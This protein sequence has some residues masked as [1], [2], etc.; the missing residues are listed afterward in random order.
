MS[1]AE[2][3]SFLFPIIAKFSD[4]GSADT[5]V[6]RVNG[7]FQSIDVNGNGTIEKGEWLKAATSST[8]LREAAQEFVELGPLLQP[9]HWRQE[10]QNLDT[11]KDSHVSATEFF[12][13]VF[14][15]VWK[16]HGIKSVILSVFASV[17]K[18]GNGEIEKS[19]WLKAATSSTRVQQFAKSYPRVAPLL[20]PGKWRAVSFYTDGVEERHLGRARS[21][22]PM[23]A[24]FC[25]VLCSTPSAICHVVFSYC[26][27]LHFDH[28]YPYLT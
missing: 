28:V 18:N 23:F 12:A 25:P 4:Y 8:I 5:V 21:V 9:A 17:D 26:S 20:K 14:P 19:E 13:F 16:Q 7:I 15:I 24:I 3:Y 22:A 2:F 1:L 10:F 11:N 27:C 6:D